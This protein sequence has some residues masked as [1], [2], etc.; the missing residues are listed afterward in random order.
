MSVCNNPTKVRPRGENPRTSCKGTFPKIRNEDH[1]I[2]H[3]CK[4]PKGGTKTVGAPQYVLSVQN[5]TN[6]TDFLPGS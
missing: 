3:S 6:G 5:P 2:V 1:L 4:R